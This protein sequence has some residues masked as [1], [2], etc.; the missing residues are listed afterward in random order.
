VL[1]AQI[2]LRRQLPVEATCSINDLSGTDTG[3][4]LVVQ[5]DPP[6]IFDAGQPYTVTRR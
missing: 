3:D 4:K 5:D 2:I 6:T 1:V